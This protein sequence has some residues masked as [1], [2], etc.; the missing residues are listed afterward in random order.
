MPTLINLT[1]HPSGRWSNDQ[2]QVCQKKGQIVDL[3]FPQIA[4]DC[5]RKQMDD[6]TDSYLQEI[7]KFENPSVLIQGEMVFTYSLVRRLEER[8]IP[9]YAAITTR[10]A[11]ESI[12]PD[13]SSFK[14]SVFRFQG[15]R[16]YF[17][18]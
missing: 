3:P 6:L 12:Q 9:A 8:K 13:G 5:S 14:Q 4:S 18:I 15:L 11:V 16:P 17:E 2:I 7:Q 1:N 10:E